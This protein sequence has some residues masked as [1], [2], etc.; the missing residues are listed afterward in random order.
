MGEKENK[1]GE[2]ERGSKL[3]IRQAR[4]CFGDQVRKKSNS[5]AENHPNVADD[6]RQDQRGNEQIRGVKARAR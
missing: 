1:K 2:L 5:G 3:P 4:N 6:T